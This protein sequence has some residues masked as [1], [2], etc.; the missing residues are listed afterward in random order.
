MKQLV[1]LV[2]L[3][4]GLSQSV[5]GAD[6]NQAIIQSII[7]IHK[8][9]EKLG[10]EA[11]LKK[12]KWDLPKPQEE[13]L[14]FA[15]MQVIRT[16]DPFDEC[17]WNPSAPGCPGSGGFYPDPFGTNPT[18]QLKDDGLQIVATEVLYQTLTYYKVKHVFGK[19]K[20]NVWGFKVI[21]ARDGEPFQDIEIDIVIGAIKQFRRYVAGLLCNNPD[22]ARML[23]MLKAYNLGQ[24]FRWDMAWALLGNDLPEAPNRYMKFGSRWRKFSAAIDGIQNGS[25]MRL[26]NLNG[27]MI[28]YNAGNAAQAVGAA[29]GSS[30]MHIGFIAREIVGIIQL[31]GDIISE[32]LNLFCISDLSFDKNKEAQKQQSV[33][34]LLAIKKDLYDRY[35]SMRKI[36]DEMGKQTSSITGRNMSFLP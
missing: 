31:I 4:M 35:S 16:N 8:E 25:I 34:K 3:S 10:L 27:E 20:A 24:R 13:N 5:L 7:S 29:T 12:A 6:R 18:M 21:D 22:P 19:V 17:I 26:R 1:V 23:G 30:A 14:F 15:P 28:N 36:L 2:V 11:V 9:V 32:A 33:I